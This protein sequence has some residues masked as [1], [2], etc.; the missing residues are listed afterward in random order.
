MS[1]P[2]IE[3]VHGD[4]YLAKARELLVESVKNVRLVAEVLR[5]Y[6]LFLWPYI[7][8]KEPKTIADYASSIFMH[9]HARVRTVT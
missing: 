9:I 2:V 3:E 7:R 1:L 6:S 5:R 8:L 4:G